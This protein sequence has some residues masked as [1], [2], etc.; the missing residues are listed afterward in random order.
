[1]DERLGRGVLAFALAVLGSSLLLLPA[2]VAAEPPS[3]TLDSPGGMT[4]TLAA[5][6]IEPD[7]LFE[8]DLGLEG[9]GSD[10]DPIEPL[11]RVFF[12]ANQALDWVLWNPL[13]RGYQIVVPEPARRGVYRVFRNLNSPSIIVNKLLQR[14]FEG[15]AKALGRFTTTPTSVRPW[16]WRAFRAVPIS[17]FRCSAPPR[18]ETDS[19]TRSTSFCTR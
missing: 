1:M 18:S 13:T 9:D 12:T 10:R 19:A 3:Q 8:E 11:N 17:C 2:P 4:E 5:Q 6:E 15:A 7:P 16:P 14:R